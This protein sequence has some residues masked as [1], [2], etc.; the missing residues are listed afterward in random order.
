MFRLTL[1]LKNRIRN[2]NLNKN[3][4]KLVN[5]PKKNP[6]VS[7]L[8]LGT[9]KT[10]GCDLIVQKYI[11]KKENIDIKRNLI[12]SSFGFFYLGFAQWF[13][14]MNV[15]GR[16]FPGMSKFANQ[17]FKDKLKNKD[18][19]KLMLKQV[20]ADNLLHNPFCYFPCF[21]L[22]KEIVKCENRELILQNTIKTYKSNFWE[23][24]MK[25]IMVFVP[26][27]ILAFSAPIWLRFPIIHIASFVWTCY[28]SFL[29]G[30]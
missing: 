7:N 19:I 4:D 2:N 9:I 29:R 12:F 27:D 25:I 5:F 28:L 23:D 30:S 15:F 24:N 16:F 26:C 11:E 6:F 18:G 21:Y 3:L 10:S 8:L 17:S 22:C 14:F 20:A 1:F 13:I